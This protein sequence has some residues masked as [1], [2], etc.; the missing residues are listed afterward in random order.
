MEMTFTKG[1]MIAC[2]AAGAVLATVSIV[3][4]VM[5]VSLT[6]RDG[7]G[8][9]LAPLT[10]ILPPVSVTLDNEVRQMSVRVVVD[11]P[12]ERDLLCA[13]VRRLQGAIAREAA[14]LGP[15]AG[16]ADDLDR[17]LRRRLDSVVGENLIERIDVTV[18]PRGGAVPAGNCPPAGT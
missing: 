2:G 6:N 3:G 5:D 14:V 17:A 11:G 16:L 8:N 12:R 18:T 10:V 7:A 4:Q 15:K 13:Q 9:P 1:V